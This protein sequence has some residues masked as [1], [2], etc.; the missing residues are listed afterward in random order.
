MIVENRFGE[1]H[2]LLHPPDQLCLPAEKDGQPRLAELD[3]FKCYRVR[4][5]PGTPRFE[6]QTVTLQDQFETKQTQV[7]R[8]RLLCTP[9]ERDGGG[10][11][12]PSSDLTCYSI[13]DLPAQP[14]LESRDVSVLDAFG[15][16][17][18]RVLRSSDSRRFHLCVP[19]RT[20]QP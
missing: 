17:D 4:R 14:Q 19:S 5:K 13:K 7:L 9:V 6:E 11:L 15:T 3:P 8:P 16:L 18:L 10:I 1:Q 2:L 20:R 12:D